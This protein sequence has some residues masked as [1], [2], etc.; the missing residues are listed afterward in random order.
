MTIMKNQTQNQSIY[1]KGAAILF[2]LLIWQIAA[3]FMKN[4]IVFV[5]PVDMLRSLLEQIQKA[6]FWLSL[7]NSMLKIMGGFLCAFTAGIFFAVLAWRFSM[8][9]TLLEPLVQLAKSVP[10]ASLVVL[11]LIFMGSEN[12]SIV[13]VFLMAFPMIYVNMGQGLTHV[14]PKMLEMARVFHMRPWK[15]FLY[16]YR[17]AFLPFLVSGS[18]IALGMSWKSGVAG[19]IIG[20]PS[21]SIGE[22]LYMAKIY[23]NTESLFAWTLVIILLSVFFEKLFLFL[24]KKAGGKAW[25]GEKAS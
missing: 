24:L 22:Q 12:L 21:H 9:Q 20:V 10:V 11:L 18:R 16:L 14:D 17:P 5:G 2:W 8:I 23:L 1:K 4:S 7:G 19:E 3:V 15:Q 6:E 25:K 13:L